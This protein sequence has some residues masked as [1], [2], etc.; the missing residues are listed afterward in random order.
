MYLRKIFPTFLSMCSLIALSESTPIAAEGY[1]ESESCFSTP[2][3]CD[4]PYGVYVSGEYLYWKAVQDQMQYAM[5][6][7]GG[8]QQIIQ[9]IDPSGPVQIEEKLRIV[10][11]SFK[12]NSGFRVALGYEI[13]CS[14]WDF[15][16]AWTRLHENVSSCVFNEDQG[17]IP[18]T[19]PASSIFGFITASSPA[20]FAFGDS[21]SSRWKF[22]FDAIDAEVGRLFSFLGCLNFRPYIGVKAAS[23][24]QTQ[25]VQ[26]AGFF[27]GDIPVGLRNT[28]KNDFRGIGPSLGLDSTWEFYSGWS[29]SSGVSGAILCGEFDVHE[30]ASVTV[31]PNFIHV[32]L[33]NSKKWRVRPTVAANIGID[34]TTSF[35]DSFQMM[36]GVS[37]EAQYWWNQ[38]QVPPSIT[39]SIVTGGASP[40]GDLSMQGLTARLAVLF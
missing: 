34:W 35:W 36:L 13:P 20:D 28:K 17:V 26:F 22:E 33:K 25:Q 29:L 38:W 24:R 12:Y 16:I 31:D 4:M 15:Q 39:G 10:D 27:V 8:I 40:Q 30:K 11:P 18:L 6:L 23:I 19:L 2:A 1:Y 7:P 5:I 21:A 37:Y 32:D 9:S 14:N 3:C